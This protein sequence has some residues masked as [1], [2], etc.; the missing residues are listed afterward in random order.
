MIRIQ[1]IVSKRPFILPVPFS[2][3]PLAGHIRE[4]L[5]SL[6]LRFWLVQPFR[7]YWVVYDPATKPLQVIR[8]LHPAR[9][10]SLILR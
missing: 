9:N 4:D 5:T 7:N 1:L 3:I 2:W 10:I 8:I 6:P